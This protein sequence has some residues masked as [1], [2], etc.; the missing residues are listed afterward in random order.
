MFWDTRGLTFGRQTFCLTGACLNSAI[1]FDQ[2]L[3]LRW[4]CSHLI[5][6]LEV[7][8]E[9]N[10]ITC[11]GRDKRYGKAFSTSVT[12][13]NFYI[14]SYTRHKH[15][16]WWIQQY[17]MRLPSAAWNTQKW[18]AKIPN[19]FSVM[20]LVLLKHLLKCVWLWLNSFSLY[21]IQIFL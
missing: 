3:S 19:T 6:C 9:I 8:M 2:K 15:P 14:K 11:V 21:S 12:L 17:L 5:F 13:I 4:I 18:L 10:V 20:C 7:H 1:R 16:S